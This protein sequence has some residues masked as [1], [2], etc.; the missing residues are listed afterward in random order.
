MWESR[1]VATTWITFS[2]YKSCLIYIS[3][4]IYIYIYIS[5]SITFIATTLLLSHISLECVESKKQGAA[6]SSGQYA[7]SG[8]KIVEGN[9]GTIPSKFAGSRSASSEQW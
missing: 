8:G 3:I 4:Y 7:S 9:A 6:E 5:W 2:I 1:L